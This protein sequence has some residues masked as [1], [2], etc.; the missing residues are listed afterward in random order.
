MTIDDDLGRDLANSLTYVGSQSS[1][2]RG[3]VE[4]LTE[5]A[6]ARSRRRGGVRWAPLAAAAA[7]LVLLALTGIVVLRH[8]PGP[9]GQPATTGAPPTYGGRSASSL[10]SARWTSLPEAPLENRSYAVSAW[11]GSHMLVWGGTTPSNG[12]RTFADGASYDPVA[13]VWSR[14]PSAPIA[15]RGEA[16]ST[17]TGSVLFVWGGRAAGDVGQLTDGATYDPVTRAWHRLPPAPVTRYQQAVALT[18]GGS[19]VLLTTPPGDDARQVQVQTY[20]PDSDTW[21]RWPD[22]DLPADHGAVQIDGVSTGDRIL[23][24][25]MWAR[26][27][28]VGT[29]GADGVYG[30]STTFGID[31][32]S[33]DVARQR[34]APNRLGGPAVTA[35]RQPLWTGQEVLL[36]ASQ[37]F[38][39][40]C[41]APLHTDLTGLRLDPSTSALS[42]IPHGPVDDAGPTDL[43]T[44]SALLAVD[45]RSQMGGPQ[46]SLQPGAAAVWDPATGRWTRLPDAPLGGSNEG[47]VVWTGHSVLIWG[48]FYGGRYPA[49]RSGGLELG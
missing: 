47:V 8:D 20:R 13:R 26:T 10:A 32:F 24:W 46:G 30:T 23:L 33:Y 22:L 19:V 37:P 1:P 16:V 3:L 48:T 31:S 6:G 17:W 49:T 38:C 29:N 15:G 2:P 11:T 5:G 28:P 39:G 43:W 4:R 14:L 18:V 44:G 45:T 42:Q 9:V 7:V 34:W 41:Q 27:V 35:V 25:S 12:G 40:G 36:P 21:A